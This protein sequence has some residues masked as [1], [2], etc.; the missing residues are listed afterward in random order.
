MLTGEQAAHWAP[1]GWQRMRLPNWN[2]RWRALI[3]SGWLLLYRKPPL[4]SWMCNC[5]FGRSYFS[6]YE[7]LTQLGCEGREKNPITVILGIS[8]VWKSVLLL[9]HNNLSQEP[10]VTLPNSAWMWQAGHGNFWD[11]WWEGHPQQTEMAEIRFWCLCR[12]SH[13]A[14]TWE[15]AAAASAGVGYETQPWVS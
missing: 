11:P 15:W 9:S 8:N 4:F 12:G 5:W 7:V 1:Q 13:T 14:A 3:F 2:G 10:H 6:A